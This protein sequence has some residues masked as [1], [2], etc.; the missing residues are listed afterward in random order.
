[1]FFP[2]EQNLVGLQDILKRI[3][4]QKSINDDNLIFVASRV[5]PGDDEAEILGKN[6]KRFERDLLVSAGLTET[7]I[8]RL[9][10]K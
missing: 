9:H 2:N 8:F 5:P 1:M 4:I 10:Q 6:I 7:K 3:R